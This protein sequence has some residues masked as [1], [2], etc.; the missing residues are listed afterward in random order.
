VLGESLYGGLVEVLKVELGIG[1]DLLP[2]RS[3]QPGG[4]GPE[5]VIPATRVDLVF[6]GPRQGPVGG[7]VPIAGKELER[8]QGQWIVLAGQHGM[9]VTT[10]G[11]RCELAGADVQKTRKVGAFGAGGR[12]AVEEGCARRPAIHLAAFQQHAQH[13]HEE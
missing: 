6:Y 5:L 3:A 12:D 9:Q 13:L 8:D 2:V 7:I 10:H 4:R 11:R 1:G